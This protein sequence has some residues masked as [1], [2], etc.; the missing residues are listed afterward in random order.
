MKSIPSQYFILIKPSKKQMSK[1]EFCH[2]NYFPDNSEMLEIGSSIVI[3]TQ[4]KNN[5]F[6]FMYLE[7]TINSTDSISVEIKYVN[8]NAPTTTVSILKNVCCTAYMYVSTDQQ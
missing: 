3:S 7:F 2:L 4:D 5:G 6:E 1:F 8:D